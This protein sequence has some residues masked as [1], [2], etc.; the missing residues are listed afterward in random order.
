MTVVILL[1]V[2]TQNTGVLDV[3]PQLLLA[4]ETCHVNR[5]IVIIIECHNRMI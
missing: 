2:P 5:A 4:G 3:M 1:R